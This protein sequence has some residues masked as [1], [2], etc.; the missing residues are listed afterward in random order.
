MKAWRKDAPRVKAFA[1]K[2]GKHI[3]G[4]RYG[5]ALAAA[6]R[7]LSKVKPDPSRLLLALIMNMIFETVKIHAGEA[8][9]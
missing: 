7:T 8:D 6:N 1:V 2:A 4:R 3:P 5:R 9:V